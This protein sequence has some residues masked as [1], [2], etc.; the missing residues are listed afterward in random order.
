[1]INIVQLRNKYIAF[2]CQGQYIIWFKQSEKAL[3]F[4]DKI[5]EI[6]NRKLLLKFIDKEIEKRQNEN[7]D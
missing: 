4:M 6:K 7:N 2:E 5:R 3:E 1:M